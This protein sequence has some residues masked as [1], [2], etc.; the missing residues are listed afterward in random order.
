MSD[1]GKKLKTEYSFADFLFYLCLLAVPVFAA[2]V[3]I[4]RHS[5]A[6]TLVFLIFSAGMVALLLK[7]FCTRCPHY[8]R[9]GTSLKCIF[10]W[11]LPKFFTPRGG[12]YDKID[13]AV[14]VLAAAAVAVFPL[15]WLLKEPGLLI[16]YVLSAAGFGAAIYRNECERCINSAC[17]MNRAA[18]STDSPQAH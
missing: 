18:A 13:L 10:F 11:N 12:H 17:P 1:S 3:A 16:I 14:T 4:Y 2:I 9:E 15:Y 8:T 7:F 6:W 5:P